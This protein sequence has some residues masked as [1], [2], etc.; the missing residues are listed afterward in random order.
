MGIENLEYLGVPPTSLFNS[1]Q[2]LSSWSN[3]AL[4]HSAPGTPASR[5]LVKGDFTTGIT[6]SS[7]L[8][9]GHM[10]KPKHKLVDDPLVGSL[11]FFRE[12][13]LQFYGTFCFGPLVGDQF[14]LTQ[15]PTASS[16]ELASLQIRNISYTV[17]L[18]PRCLFL[19]L[20]I[21]A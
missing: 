16:L 12:V 5:N 15:Q 4:Q 3:P 17:T 6:P 20:Y 9:V 21:K 14:S 8:L 10:S 13:S 11:W 1:E 7:S 19:A 2:S 18:P